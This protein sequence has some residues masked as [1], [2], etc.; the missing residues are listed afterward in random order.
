MFTFSY[1][2]AFLLLP[3]PLLVRWLSRPHQEVRP[4]VRTPFFD[5]LVA[6]TGQTPSSGSIIR[7]ESRTRQIVVSL[8]WVLLVAAMARPQWIEKPIVKQ[9]ASRDLLL[10][11]DLSGSMNAEDFATA[12]GKKIQRLAAV[13]QVLDSFLKRRQGDRVGLIFFG[14]APFIQAPFTEDLETCS[15]LMTDAEVG[16]CGPRTAFGDAVGLAINMFKDSKMETKL[17]IML[18]DGND[19]ASKLPPQKAAEIAQSS[20]I[21][22]YTVAIGDP[23]AVG[24]EKLDEK[25][26]KEVARTTGGRY[27]WAGDR[28]NLETI[29]QEIDKITARKVQTISYRPKRELY[30]WPLGAAIVLSLLFHSGRLV[31]TARR[32][33]KPAA[34]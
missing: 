24:E 19:T 1:I 32:R 12:D 28:K 18:T 5:E 30:Q 8:C 29:Y 20:G 11:V 3:L 26:L 15:E 17:L 31:H 14:T 2:W 21:V 13:K 9:V 6:L 34:N 33:P 7:R 4:A 25:T 16:M 10:G 22:I 27:F 23:T